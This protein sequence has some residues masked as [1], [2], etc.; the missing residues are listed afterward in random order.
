MNSSKKIIFWL[1]VLSIICGQIIKLP[2][3][4]SSGPTLLDINIAILSIYLAVK[5]RFRLKTPLFIKTGLIFTFVC[6]L[7]LLFTPLTLT[8]NQ[9]LIS[10][11]YTLR[12]FFYLLFAW[13]IY[14]TESLEP[15]NI[16]RL[17]IYSGLTIAIL[18]LLQFIFLPDLQFLQPLGWDPHYFRAASTFLDP[19]FLG[20]FLVII[21]LLI[22]PK[23]E[24]TK[25][26]SNL[27]L[28]LV[29]ITLM[30]TFSRSSYLMFTIS[31]LT[32]S[33]LKRSIKLFIAT[34]VLSAILLLGFQAYTQLVSKPHNIDRTKSASFRLNTW[35]QGLNLF[36]KS[37]L[38]GVGFNSYRF[39][40]DQYDL[41][42]DDNFLSS[43]GA[44]TN[45]FSLLYVL[46]TTGVLGLASFLLFL[47]SLLKYGFSN[48]KNPLSLVLICSISGLLIHS[49]FNNNLFY[50]FI[51]IPLLLITCAIPRK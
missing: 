21:L 18:G 46:A 33:S 22:Y 13:S 40:L 27:L 32:L 16:S 48:L 25:K 12:F 43:R 23:S 49:V 37:P 20:A 42:L 30:L 45:D 31:F 7:S 9:Y 29:Y 50:P 44:T 15:T 8:T 19:N 6:L 11:S 4:G 5:L 47:G 24:K 35:Q 34:L 36:Q 28:V 26:W 17:L 39:G 38:L 51:L 1:L 14:S 3:F 2:L 10:I 41:S